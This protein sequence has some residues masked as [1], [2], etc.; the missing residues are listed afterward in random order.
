MRH[1]RRRARTA[2]PRRGPSAPTAPGLVKFRIKASRLRVAHSDAEALPFSFEESGL[3]GVRPSNLDV[4]AAVATLHREHDVGS[5]AVAV[6]PHGVLAAPSLS[7]HAA[8]TT[9]AA[10]RSARGSSGASRS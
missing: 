10:L 7:A 1:E 2:S 6:L 9:L 5:R 3:P 4:P 8:S